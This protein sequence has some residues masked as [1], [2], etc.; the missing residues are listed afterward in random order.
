MSAKDTDTNAS[1]IYNFKLHLYP[2]VIVTFDII[3]YVAGT[4][5]PKIKG[6]QRATYL[7]SPWFEGNIFDVILAI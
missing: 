7:M 6:I 3:I 1:T 2:V 4:F 5:A